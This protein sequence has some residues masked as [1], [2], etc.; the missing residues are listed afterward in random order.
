MKKQAERAREFDPSNAASYAFLGAYEF[1][2]RRLDMAE[3]LLQEFIERDPNLGMA[4]TYLGNVLFERGDRDRALDQWTVG[5]RLD[6][7]DPEALSSLA[8]GLMTIDQVPEAKRLYEKALLRDRRYYDPAFLANRKKGA[9][10]GS[11]KVDTLRPLIQIVPKPA[12]PPTDAGET[13]SQTLAV[14]EPSGPFEGQEGVKNSGLSQAP[15]EHLL[16]RK[17]LPRAR[18]TVPAFFHSFL[19]H[20]SQNTSTQGQSRDSHGAGPAHSPRY[21]YDH[22]WKTITTANHHPRSPDRQGD[23]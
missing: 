20:S 10:W 13:E 23:G 4:R 16:I 1:R 11:E 9:A 18:L 19:S 22:A 5:A 6:P 14:A 7:I 12:Y 17:D 15:V 2:I 3:R 21:F 8:V